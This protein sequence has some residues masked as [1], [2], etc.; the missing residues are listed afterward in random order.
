M[1]IHVSNSKIDNILKNI[2]INSEIEV[3]NIEDYIILH[4]FE[5]IL[6]YVKIKYY[7]KDR[8]E[9]YVISMLNIED[10]EEYKKIRKIVAEN[11]DIDI[12]L[13]L[14][15]IPWK[16]AFKI[17]Q[18]KY[19]TTSENIENLI[20]TSWM[21]TR[22]H[23]HTYARS[24]LENYI[25]D[26]VRDSLDILKI[27]ALILFGILDIRKIPYNSI[28]VKSNDI[29]KYF[30]WTILQIDNNNIITI[31]KACDR[32]YVLSNQSIISEQARIT[33]PEECKIIQK[34]EH[35]ILIKNKVEKILICATTDKEKQELDIEYEKINIKGPDLDYEDNNNKIKITIP[36]NTL[37]IIRGKFKTN[38][39]KQ[40]QKDEEELTN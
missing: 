15:I 5:K 9:E 19:R 21:L 34:E 4:R 26:K 32:E 31:F 16:D 17:L 27:V 7:P 33:I 14:R 36:Q 29:F 22:Y 23:M 25:I 24:I 10:I 40:K 18:E 35:K 12:K 11:A 8:I 2:E 13:M 37:Y 28:S 1:K 6:K 38:D 30:N 39:E 20:Q 3:K